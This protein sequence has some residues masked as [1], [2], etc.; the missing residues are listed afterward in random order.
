MIEAVYEST[1]GIC[2]GRIY[3]GDQIQCVDDEWCHVECAEDE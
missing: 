1:C 2:L 3:E